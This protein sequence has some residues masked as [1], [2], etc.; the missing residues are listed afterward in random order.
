[1]TLRASEPSEE[2]LE[3]TSRH[4]YKRYMSQPTHITIVSGSAM[5]M[6]QSSSVT[7]HAQHLRDAPYGQHVPNLMCMCMCVREAR[8]E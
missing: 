4:A 2:L 8:G 3:V 5:A 1:M 7:C 6:Y